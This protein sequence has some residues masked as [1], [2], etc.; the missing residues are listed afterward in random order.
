MKSDTSATTV[1]V[2]S[3]SGYKANERPLSFVIKGLEKKVVEIKE[4]WIGPDTDYFK[5]K[6]DDEKMYILRWN[7]QEDMWGIE[8]AD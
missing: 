8:N 4:R 5:I 2:K 7:R 6:A 3:Y 1:R